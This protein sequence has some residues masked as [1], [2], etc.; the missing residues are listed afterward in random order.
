MMKRTIFV[1]LLFILLLTYGCNAQKTEQSPV[2]NSVQESTVQ[3][4]SASESLAEPT[5][6][7]T[8]PIPTVF[9]T[10]IDTVAADGVPIKSKEAFSE[11][12]TSDILEAYEALKRYYDYCYGGRFPNASQYITSIDDVRLVRTFYT[13]YDPQTTDFHPEKEYEF[14]VTCS[15]LEEISSSRKNEYYAV[16]KVDGEWTTLTEYSM[17]HEE[18]QISE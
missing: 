2:G 7:T 14:Y 16:S 1:C 10:P 4:E 5:E 12:E 13:R 3:T 15:E 6:K 8:D 17:K 9:R 18:T 11:E